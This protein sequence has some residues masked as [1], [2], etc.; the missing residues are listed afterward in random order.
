M[1]KW[2]GGG[3][4]ERAEEGL[5]RPYSHVTRTV[6][7]FLAHQEHLQSYLDNLTSPPKPPQGARCCLSS[8]H[9]RDREQVQHHV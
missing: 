5:S 6:Y 2:G 4:G 7:T 9:F 3:P 8:P 1:S